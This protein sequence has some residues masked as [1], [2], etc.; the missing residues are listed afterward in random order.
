MDKQYVYDFE[1]LGFGLFVHYGLY[2]VIGSGEWA[3]DI[4]KLD[5]HKYQKLT[6]KFKVKKTWAKEIVS[7]AKKAGCKYITLTT[8]HHDGF[9]LYDTKGLSDYDVIH[10]ACGRDLIKEF[11]VEC[12]KQNIV[13][14]FYHTLLDW[15][16][17]EYKTDFNAYIDYLVSSIEILC[18]EYGKVGG[19]W[20]DGWWDKKDANWQFD[21]LYGT[22]RKYQPQAMIINNTGLSAKGQVGHP[23][24]D[25]V[26]F[27]RGKP[28]AFVDR[29]MR[30]IAGE[31][32]QI[33]NSHWGFARKD[34]NY[35]SLKTFIED[36]IDCRKYNCNYLLNIGPRENGTLRTIEKGILEEIGKWVDLNKKFIYNVKGCD[37]TAENAD[38][39]T[40]GGRYYA[41]MKNVVMSGN[42]N[43]T[44]E[45]G[46]AQKVIINAKIKS[47]KWLDSGK[48]IQVKDNSFY[49]E[50]FMYGSN[51]CV[52]VAVLDLE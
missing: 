25:C 32:C 2:S 4:L 46:G 15:H 18:T 51:M 52:R 24:I 48:K 43:V 30:P 10:S 19:F 27:E 12:R 47:A 22:I 37:I 1:K 20:F 3:L 49:A 45:S 39:L 29:S 38:I 36:L 42:P 33:F 34:V 7:Y 35:K 21:R 26:T 6:E 23:E 40:D 44:I 50:P 11:V 13:P 14:F 41:V 28:T 8:R 9:S 17:K 5:E 16:K 31:M